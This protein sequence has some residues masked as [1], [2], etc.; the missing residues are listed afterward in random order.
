MKKAMLVGILAIA[1]SLAACS[2]ARQKTPSEVVT[3]IYM[4]ANAGLYSE[5]EEHFSAELLKSLKDEWGALMV[6]LESA[7]DMATNYGTIERIEITEE[8]IRGEGAIVG[9]R[10]HFEDGSTR[11][12]YEALILE[13]RVWKLTIWIDEV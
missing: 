5:T 11:D 13:R 10:L 8:T 3:E 6:E 2:P 4:A 7:W 12:D 9:F 1:A